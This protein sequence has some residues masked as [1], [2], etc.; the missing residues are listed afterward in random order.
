MTLTSRKALVANAEHAV[1]DTGRSN[2]Q[3]TPTLKTIFRHSLPHTNL[4][5]TGTDNAK[6]NMI[7]MG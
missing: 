4:L 7:L 5:Y 1:H 3:Q 2:G 6:S